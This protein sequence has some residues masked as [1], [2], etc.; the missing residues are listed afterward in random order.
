MR[1]PERC[2]IKQTSQAASLWCAKKQ[3]NGTRPKSAI[4]AVPA[5]S[6]AAA[7]EDGVL[8]AV[9]VVPWTSAMGWGAVEVELRVL[10]LV[11]GTV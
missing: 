5:W 8:E 10:K 7:G 6:G 3:A 11:T 1:A 4:G 9:S 2:L